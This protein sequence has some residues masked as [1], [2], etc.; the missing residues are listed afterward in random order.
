[1]IRLLYL[2][3]MQWFYLAI[4]QV[5]ARQTSFN[6]TGVKVLTNE[7]IRTPK[8]EFS[9]KNFFIGYIILAKPTLNTPWG[10]S[11]IKIGNYPLSLSY[12]AGSLSTPISSS[13]TCRDDLDSH[14]K[15]WCCIWQ[16]VPTSPP[17]QCGN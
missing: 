3:R 6:K 8:W 11:I 10:F 13:D 7:K 12:L 9:L 16:C 1:M 17:I 15:D 4:S 2:Y 14:K 5:I